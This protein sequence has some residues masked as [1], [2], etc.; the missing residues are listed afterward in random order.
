[1]KIGVILEDLGMSQLSYSVISNINKACEHN[2]ENDYIIFFNNMVAPVIP[3]NCALM[4]SSEI[5]SFDGHLIGTSVATTLMA[6]KSINS[7]KKYFYV[8]DLEWTR[9]AQH[10]QY[11]QD[12]PAFRSRGVSLIARSK[13]HAAAIQNY[14]NRK[15]S[16][17]VPDFDIENMHEVINN[18]S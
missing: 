11:S 2:S 5:W 10:R 13:E 7:A 18:E 3:P 14:S 8:W 4:N 15:V 17:I 12:I 6:L 9:H 1:M 16:H